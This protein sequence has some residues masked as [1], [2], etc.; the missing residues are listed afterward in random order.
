MTKKKKLKKTCNYSMHDKKCEEDLHDN[1][2]CIF[3]SKVI[4]KRKKDV[5]DDRL[6]IEIKRQE[7]NEEIFDFTGFVFPNDNPF[8]TLT[9]EKKV[10]LSGAQF[11]GK[12]TFG[13][14]RFEEDVYFS[15][16]QFNGGVSFWNA[17]FSGR[18]DFTGSQFK[19]K[20]DFR[21]A[22]FFKDAVFV[23]AHFSCRADFEGAQ[24][25][26]KAD[27][28]QAKFTGEAVFRQSQF[29]KNAVFGEAHF[30][31]KTDF[32]LVNFFGEAFFKEVN[33]NEKVYFWKSK[34]HKRTDFIRAQFSAEANFEKAQFS[35]ETNFSQCKFNEIAIFDNVDFQKGKICFMEETYF[36]DISG[37]LEFLDEDIKKKKKDR[38]FKYSHKTELL[39]DHFSLILGE[40][41]RDKYPLIN[42]VIKDDIYLIN[43]KEKHPFVHFLW[44]LL[45][46]CGRKRGYKRWFLWSVGTAVIFG[47]IYAVLGK[48]FPNSFDIPAGSTLISYFYFSIVTFTTLGF[49]DITPLE[50][51]TQVLV[52]IEVILGY[53]I[54]GVLIG[55]LVNT[56]T[57]KSS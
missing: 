4:N 30:S 29:R 50:W 57:R 40:K 53:V 11:L 12:I 21:H 3:H 41:A 2:H 36:N 47:V 24:F 27:F 51:Y 32:K 33:F 14:A 45:A 23:E 1:V 5:F 8:K 26:Q 25:Y 46:D 52:T 18:A 19:I 31:K 56:L 20:A 10:I 6:K 7:K 13:R 37:L 54:L 39:P 22:N 48:L 9:F 49:G 16:T 34:F 15:D 43:L 17:Q 55:M 42:R 44:W 28:M 35:G 38:K